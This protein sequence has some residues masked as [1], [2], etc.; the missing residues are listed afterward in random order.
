[1]ASWRSNGARHDTVVIVWIIALFAITALGAVPLW[2]YRLDLSKLT[3][4]TPVPIVA[5]V[6]IEITAYAPTLAAILTVAV[7]PGGGGVGR[8]LRPIGKWRSGIH[9]YILALLGPSLLFLI[10]DVVRLALGLPL[11]PHWLAIP[12]AAAL[13]FL[14]GALIAGSFG[15]EV[16]W[17][18]FAPVKPARSARS[19]LLE[20]STAATSRFSRL[21]AISRFP[22]RSLLP[23]TPAKFANRMRLSTCVDGA[24]RRHQSADR[25]LRQ[26]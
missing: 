21:R 9:W 5:G 7:V 6:G 20:C 19:T 13:A 23:T 3:F 2:F 8:L 17:R 12:G 24:T 15:E 10:G 16:G 11:P 14:T 26:M 25:A 18:G 4:S 1:M 22:P